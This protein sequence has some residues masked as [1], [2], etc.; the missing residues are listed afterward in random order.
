MYPE[1]HTP[2]NHEINELIKK[3]WSPMAFS[4]QKIDEAKIMSL[5]EAARWA[6]SSFNG[7]PWHFIYATQD[8]PNE[9]EKITSLLA[10]GN[11]WA[12]N[13]YIVA[14]ICASKNFEYKNKPNRHYAYDTGAAAQNLNLQA[15]SMGLVTH[16]MAGFDVDGAP[17]VLNIP[18]NVEPMA[19]IAIGHPGKVEELSDDLKE[20]QKSERERKDISEFIHKGS[21]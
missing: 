6:P 15:A 5:F 13:A 1:K 2:N 14:L 8:Q 20:R 17:E 18:E 7:Q 9:F 12:K 21:W 4:N 10:E 16:E 3:R 11:S 19:M